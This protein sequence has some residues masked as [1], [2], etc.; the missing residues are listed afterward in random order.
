MATSYEII[1]VG[2]ILSAD[3]FSAAVAMGLRPFT[4]KDALKFAASSG[5]AEAGVALI[6]VLAGSYIISRFAAIDHWIAFTLLMAV[7][8]HM[9]YEGIIHLLNKDKEEI[10]EEIKEFHSFG[11]V[12]IVSLATSLDAFGVG[13]GLGIAHKPIVPF[14]LSIGFW[15]FAT[16]LAGMYL[17]RKLSAK[18]GP[19]MNLVGATVLAI[20]AFEMLKI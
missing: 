13:I 6:G 4:R 15:A 8:L 3:S 18:F 5:G 12:L 2:L 16:T 20:M 7:A 17:A 9:A 10:K 1:T 14:I 11:K 19:I